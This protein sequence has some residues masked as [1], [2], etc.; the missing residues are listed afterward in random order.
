MTPLPATP[1]RSRC[2]SPSR[3]SLLLALVCACGGTGAAPFAAV[4]LPVISSAAI[5]AQD[6]DEA[7]P[8]PIPVT[9]ADPTLGEPTALVTVVV[10]GDLQD[11]FY[12]G[13]AERLRALAAREGPDQ[14]RVAFKHLPMPWH[15]HARALALASAAALEVGGSAAF[16][17]FHDAAVSAPDSAPDRYEAWAEAAGIPRETFRR[18]L[19]G[20]GP[21]S[22]VDG[23]AALAES[24]KVTTGPWLFINGASC[25]ATTRCTF[26]DSGR[27][28]SLEAEIEAEKNRARAALDAGAAPVDLYAVRCADNLAHPQPPPSRP[29]AD[30]RDT[31]GA[32]RLTFGAKHLLVMYL[33]SRRAPSHVTRTREEARARAEEAARKAK[34]GANFEA[35]VAEY[36]DEPN[37]ASRGGSLGVFPRG[38]MVAEFQAGLEALRVGEISGVVETPFGFHVIVRTK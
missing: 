4:D 8:G 38:A 7:A 33:G 9:R 22:K 35:L 15:R 5:R 25:G 28:S 32:N 2:S 17:R 34:A 16:W 20:P 26:F 12:K 3:L 23:D 21:A 10:F 19:G 13:A 14:L 6:K 30:E 27:V 36:T 1:P 18:A 29:A 24:L 37:A 31:F 11:P